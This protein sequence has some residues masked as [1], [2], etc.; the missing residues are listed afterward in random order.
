MLHDAGLVA[1][2]L[3][4]VQI[5]VSGT[6][7]EFGP[8]DDRS[9]V[10]RFIEADPESSTLQFVV[11]AQRIGVA[12]PPEA[13]WGDDA[14]DWP[15]LAHSEE[16]EALRAHAGGLQLQNH[17]L[18]EHNRALQK[19]ADALRNE[20]AAWQRSTLVRV[21]NPLRSLWVRARRLASR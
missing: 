7:L 11:A 3:E 20:I 12:A 8:T 17:E 2:R 14:V 19:Q 5:G 9:D 13:L 6:N 10:V 16:A 1:V 18:L 4:R 21:T 15:S